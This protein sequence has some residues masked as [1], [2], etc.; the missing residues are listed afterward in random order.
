MRHV[1][2]HELDA[3]LLEAKQEMR[4]AG[5]PIEA[6]Y[7]ELGVEGAAGVER[8]ASAGR[9]SARFPLSTSTNSLTSCQRPPFSHASTAARWFQGGGRSRPAVGW[10]RAERRTLSLNQEDL[11]GSCTDCPRLAARRL[12]GWL[13]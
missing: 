3:G 9:L 11:S 7:D 8:S 13:V 2:R 4:V 1:D 10:K 5:E 6:T 12:G